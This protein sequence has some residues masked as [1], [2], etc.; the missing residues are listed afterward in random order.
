MS[1]PRCT[2]LSREES[3]R[4]LAGV[5]VGR[6]VF[7]RQALPA[8]QAVHH[9]VEDGQVIV[10]GYRMES[11][12]SAVD[13]VVAYEADSL[14]G[15]GADIGWSVVVTGVA[16]RLDGDDV[17]ERYRHLAAPWPADG[18]GYVIRIHPEL[19]T[20]FGRAGDNAPAS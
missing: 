4:L 13:T 5:R 9:L 16:R 3:L 8:I 1:T 20:G 17:P 14:A 10:R 15:D 6:I 2:E 19:V 7:T 18:S 11:L 12:A